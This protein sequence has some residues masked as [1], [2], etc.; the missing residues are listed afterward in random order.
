MHVTELR[1]ALWLIAS[2][3]FALAATLIVLRL[4]DKQSGSFKVALAAL[5]FAALTGCASIVLW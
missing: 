1:A 2:A 5:V 3:A 4:R